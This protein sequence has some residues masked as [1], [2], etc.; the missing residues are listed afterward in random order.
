MGFIM[1]G[2]VP[3][4]SASSMYVR[5]GVEKGSVESECVSEFRSYLGGTH[6]TKTVHYL[7]KGKHGCQIGLFSKYPRLDSMSPVR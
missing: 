6:I 5:C 2:I 3:S 1:A 4:L 7:L